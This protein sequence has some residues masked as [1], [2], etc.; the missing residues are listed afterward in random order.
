MRAVLVFLLLGSVLPSAVA[1]EITDAALEVWLDRLSDASPSM[2]ELAAS[3]LFRAGERGAQALESRNFLD[4]EARRLARDVLIALRAPTAILM[5]SPV[6]AT[7]RTVVMVEFF[8]RNRRPVPIVVEPYYVLGPKPKGQ[9]V[10]N[11]RWRVTVTPS[12]GRVVSTTP[13]MRKTFTIPPRGDASIQIPFAL[14]LEGRKTFTI[15]IRYAGQGFTLVAKQHVR[16]GTL[17]LKL[18]QRQASSPNAAVRSQAVTF[19]RYRLRSPVLDAK[20]LRMLRSVSYSGYR[21]V[22]LGVAVALREYARKNNTKLIEIACRLAADSDAVVSR[23]GIT[24]MIRLSSSRTTNRKVLRFASTAFAKPL[25]PRSRALLS[26]MQVWGPLSRRRFL[27]SVL[28]ATRSR[29]AHK[30]IASILRRDGVPVEPGPSGLVPASQI[31]ML[32]Q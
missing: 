14:K 12:I 20:F 13:D 8:V 26:A 5:V 9:W 18:V 23:A 27:G 1:D 6:V 30:E 10:V 24:A 2:R 31:R 15:Q 21:D 29:I 19:V 28:G 22:R 32:R 7:A 25:Q 4:P 3:E 16:V 11:P 17:S